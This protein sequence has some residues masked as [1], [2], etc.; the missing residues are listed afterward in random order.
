MVTRAACGSNIASS[1]QIRLTF[2]N[3]SA[4]F[5]AV[6]GPSSSAS[7]FMRCGFVL[8]TTMCVAAHSGKSVVALIPPV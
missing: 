7:P 4:S 3:T 8:P 6:Q 1:L 5:E 2:L